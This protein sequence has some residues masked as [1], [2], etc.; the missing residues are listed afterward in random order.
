M[1]KAMVCRTRTFASCNSGERRLEVRDPSVR[2]WVRVCTMS[3][4]RDRGRRP[5]Q[6]IGGVE[7]GTVAKQGISRRSGCLVIAR[8]SRGHGWQD[9]GEGRFVALGRKQKNGHVWEM[10]QA[11]IR[12]FK[13]EGGVWAVWA[14]QNL[15]RSAAAEADLELEFG[16]PGGWEKGK[17]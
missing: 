9:L 4:G 16:R 11:K 14:H 2:L 5:Y 7:A 12:R 8:R 15:R 10:R 13:Q 17:R 6:E 3:I 1:A